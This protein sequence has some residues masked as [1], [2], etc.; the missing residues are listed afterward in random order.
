MTTTGRKQLLFQCLLAIEDERLLEDV[1]N[2][3]DKH[4]PDARLKPIRDNCL[5]SV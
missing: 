3:L 4:C 2:L 1:E 5:R